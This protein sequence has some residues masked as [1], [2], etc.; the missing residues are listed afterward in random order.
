MPPEG[1]KPR[2]RPRAAAQGE[3]A[4]ELAEAHLVRCGYF[5]LARNHRCRAGEVD[6]VV[7]RGELVVFVEVRRRRRGGAVDPVT[8][9]TPAKQRRIVRAAAD[10]LQRAGLER[11][12]VRFDVVGV[13][14]RRGGPP[15]LFHL[16]G[17]FDSSVLDE[18][19]GAC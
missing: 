18:A 11:R 15:E 9:V 3:A 12:G 8:S 5:P 6:L 14:P 10:F 19:P 7:S 13:V 17:A 2:G 4:E 1:T 16:E